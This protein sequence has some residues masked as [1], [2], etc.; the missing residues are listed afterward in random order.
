M[1]LPNR[2][3]PPIIFSDI[4]RT[5]VK[6]LYNKINNY[7]YSYR[8]IF[9]SVM[10]IGG[11]TITS[12][13]AR[14]IVQKYSRVS[15]WRDVFLSNPP[16]SSR[17]VKRLMS[18]YVIITRDTRN[19]R[20]LLCYYIWYN[21]PSNNCTP[22]ARDHAT[23][24]ALLTIPIILPSFFFYDLCYCHHNTAINVTVLIIIIICY[25]TGWQ[26]NL[27]NNFLKHSAS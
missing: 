27:N 18:L 10:V 8:I 13:S 1:E 22:L 15:K 11:F 12:S 25:L 9:C 26:I 23:I 16:H 3:Y 6:F 21:R 20:I 14:I 5:A 17:H 2:W 19:Y 7:C 24:I 4:L